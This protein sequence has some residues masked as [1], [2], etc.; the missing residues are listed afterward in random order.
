MQDNINSIVATKDGSNTLFSARY[1]QHYHNPDD[2]AIQESLT[3]HIIPT[4]EFH[5]E[6]KS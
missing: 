5:K 2:G 3:K 1:N 6:K 4:L